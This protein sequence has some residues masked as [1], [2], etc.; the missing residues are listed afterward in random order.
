MLLG[1]GGLALAAVVAVQE[2]PR[3][4]I[5][6]ACVVVAA[7]LAWYG[8]LRRGALRVAGLAVGALGL[9]AAILLL[10]SER[11]VEELLVVA[12]LRPERRRAPGSRSP[13][14]PGCRTRR[15]RNDRS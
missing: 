14:A 11:L 1:F 6:L 4:L 9:S 8:V 10:A 3:G 7:A 2:F 13:H 15:R 5:A 12:A